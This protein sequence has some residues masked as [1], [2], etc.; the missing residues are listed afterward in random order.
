MQEGKFSREDIN[1]IINFTSDFYK[2]TPE[3][4]PSYTD[5]EIN[6]VL[7]CCN[8]VYQTFLG[9]ELYDSFES[10]VI[11]IIENLNRGHYLSN[12]NKRISFVIVRFLYFIEKKENNLKPYLIRDIIDGFAKGN[13]T[14]Q[15]ALLLLNPP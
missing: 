2:N 12:G 1:K 11:A 4:I 7:D 13:L 8:R 10:K 15:K 9:K 3:A 6:N 5:A 14:K